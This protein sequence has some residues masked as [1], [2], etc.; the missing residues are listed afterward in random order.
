M[1][2]TFDRI[3]VPNDVHVALSRLACM[4][5]GERLLLGTI[6]DDAIA[7]WLYANWY[8]LPAVPFS[9]SSPAPY[10]SDL[11]TVLHAALLASA[12]W[13]HGWVALQVE[14]SQR[15]IAGRGALQRMVDP[16]DY[17]N[18][19]RPGVPVVPGDGLA[20]FNLLTW[21]DPPTGFLGVRSQ[22]AQPADPLVRLYWSVASTQ[23]GYVVRELVSTL[24][25]V[26]PAWSLK[27]PSQSV[28]YG[29]VDSLVIYL[30]RENWPV[31]EP[32]IM[33][34]AHTLGPRLRDAVPPL[35]R[36]IGRGVGFAEDADPQRSFGQ[37]R[38]QALVSG[39]RRVASGSRNDPSTAVEWLVQALQSHGIDPVHPWQCNTPVDLSWRASRQRQTFD[40]QATP[41]PPPLAARIPRRAIPHAVSVSSSYLNAALAI[42]HRLH[43]E[44]QHGSNGMGWHGDDLVGDTPTNAQVVHGDI[45]PGLYS[46]AA[47]IGWFLTHLGQ[48]V[49]D[50]D[51]VQCGTTALISA[52]KRSRA[53]VA[54][55]T[56]SLYGGAS[57]VALAAMK[58]GQ[59]LNDVR[60]KR[61]ARLLARAVAQCI[62]AGDIP[63]E[64][65]L[66]GG[67]AGILVALAAVHRLTP[68][69]ELADAC[70]VAGER[71]LNTAVS[72]TSGVHWPE[73]HIGANVPGLCGLAHGVSGIAWALVDAA[74]VTGDERFA[75]LAFEAMSYERSWFSSKTSSWPDLR[76]G[77]A[78]G[79][80][81]D[82][83]TAWCHGG[84]GIAALRLHLY[85]RSGDLWALAEA[86]VGLHSA[87]SVVAAA[88]RA[89][90]AGQRFDAS[91]CH[92]LGGAVELF[93]LAY[94]VT[95]VDDHTR[96]ARRTADLCLEMLTANDGRWTNGLRGATK[97][98]GLMVGDAGIGAMMLRLHQPSAISSP[99]LPGRG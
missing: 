8:M 69:S 17:A 41:S 61:D 52:L 20:V 73:P 49:A 31:F 27:C 40:S 11:S 72:D 80:G 87:R 33:A 71:L 18:I 38:C 76:G 1:E 70:R 29:R 48:H 75:L 79:D 60:L 92:G 28:E 83:M 46:G 68:Q 45:G 35:T 90:N 15:C 23:V 53:D 50:A 7:D 95:G 44:A 21:V 55:N 6:G 42:G 99:L 26:G 59:R 36:C 4:V 88:R 62:V 74:D 54:A 93:T 30:E 97:V 39:V 43:A 91:L 89:L 98:P 37:T 56:L 66:I 81:P 51:L 13:E 5:W 9:D 85:Q 25:R 96:A 58:A 86:G 32:S 12:R 3:A 84:I 47:G 19:S 78:A 82:T 22:K 77:Q 64:T 34:L 2:V 63:S 14:P 94:E 10:R 57:G 67:T 65:D 24:E 16:G